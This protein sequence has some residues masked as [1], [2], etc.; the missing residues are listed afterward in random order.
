MSESFS[1]IAL[2]VVATALCAMVVLTGAR[3]ADAQE[4]LFAS[5]RD[6]AAYVSFLCADHGWGR[7]DARAAILIAALIGAA[8]TITVTILTARQRASFPAPA[9]TSSGARAVAW[10][11]AIFL[12][13]IA[14]NY[15]CE[16][17]MAAL[18]WN[19]AHDDFGPIAFAILGG[20][21]FSVASIWATGRILAEWPSSRIGEVPSL[22]QTE[23]PPGAAEA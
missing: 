21:V 18:K 3:G 15:C 12:Y 22:I 14:L 20:G 13:L 19:G 2:S 23:P 16:A 4:A 8:S 11:A 6:C 5:H 9:A 7:I 10:G 17:I 1:R